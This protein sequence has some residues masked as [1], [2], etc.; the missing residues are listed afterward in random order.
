MELVFGGRGIYR[1][2]REA[3]WRGGRWMGPDRAGLRA[4]LG[5]LVVGR[6]PSTSARDM[7]LMV[8]SSVR[9]GYVRIDPL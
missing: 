8:N 5:R 4:L 9:S 6:D 3:A 2:M 7:N 1:W